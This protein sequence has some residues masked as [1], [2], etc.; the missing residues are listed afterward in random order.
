MKVLGRRLNKPLLILA[1]LIVAYVARWITWKNGTVL[2]TSESPFSY[3]KTEVRVRRIPASAP[4]WAVPLSFFPP[5]S[6]RCRFEYYV[7][8]SALL[9]SAETIQFESFEKLEARIEWEP[10]GTASVY[11]GEKKAFVCDAYVN[12]IKQK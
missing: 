1:V 11:L 7:A 9:W 5:D 2:A 10:P 4:F 12:W 8:G 3:M 6:P